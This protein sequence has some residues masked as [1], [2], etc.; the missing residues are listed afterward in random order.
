MLTSGAAALSVGALAVTAAAPPDFRRAVEIQRPVNF[1]ADALPIDPGAQVEPPT[2]EDLDAALALIE[3]LAPVSD[4]RMITVR[5][6][7]E[8][9]P[10]TATV[11]P[12]ERNGAGGADTATT[13]EPSDDL[14]GIAALDEP[15]A[16][17]AASDIIDDVY[18]ISRYWANYVSLELGPWLINWVPLGYLVSDQIYIWYPNF[19]LPTV[20]SFV[21][22]FLDPVVNDPFN[23]EAWVGG[24]S[25]IISTAA[26]G[27]AEGVREEIDYIVSFGWFPIP[28]PPLPDFPLPG[29]GS[30]STSAA[31]ALTATEA[32]ESATDATEDPA[33]NGTGE[34]A[35]EVATESVDTA[36][37]D[38]SADAPTEEGN[39]EV[40]GDATLAPAEG[41]PEDSATPAEEGAEE[42]SSEGESQTQDPSQ[43]ATGD[44]ADPTYEPVDADLPDD[45]DLPGDADLP[46]DADDPS[47]ADLPADT[48]DPSD[49]DLPADTDDPS[50]NDT[51]QDTGQDAG[52]SSS[53]TSGD[54]DSTGDSDTEG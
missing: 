5:L 31:L 42:S 33:P 28:L 43:D 21:Y 39:E 51:G 34:V 18:S 48:D 50:D 3:Q 14:P 24:I 38:E 2:D 7:G 19:V 27:V 35:G 16:Q 37:P 8:D 36:T 20:D 10:Q 30:A 54:S 4:G 26:T 53:D 11:A 17:N 12:A 52:S 29:V 40:A 44:E 23:L 49:A 25:D 6:N 22:D 47:D 13:D 9:H 45:A 41:Q 46:V 15:T 32:G 1:A